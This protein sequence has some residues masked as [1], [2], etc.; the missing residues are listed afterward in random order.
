MFE[1]CDRETVI[2]QKCLFPHAVLR[3][4]QDITVR[5]HIYELG[6]RIH[7]RRRHVFE[8]ERDYIDRCRK[9]SN[10]VKV[11]VCRICLDVG[12]LPGRRVALGRKSVNAIAHLAGLDSKHPPKL[13][14]AEYTDG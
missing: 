4:V 6:R 12:D 13:P 1:R 11:L 2:G 8:F 5:K 3:S 9:L 14:A 7:R 10:G